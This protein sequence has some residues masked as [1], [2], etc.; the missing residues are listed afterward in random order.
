MIKKILGFDNY[1]IDDLGNIYG[2][3]KKLKSVRKHH[4]DGYLYVRLKKNGQSFHKA[5][6]RLMAITFLGP[7]KNGLE[8]R[9]LDG[10]KYNNNLINLSYGTRAENLL[11]DVKHGKILKK[12]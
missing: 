3:N 2:P 11:D 4:K 8:V 1:T 5:V 6:H 10:N 9:H 12:G 7:K